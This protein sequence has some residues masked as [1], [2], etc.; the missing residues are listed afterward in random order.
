[1]HRSFAAVLLNAVGSGADGAYRGGSRA[2]K[3]VSLDWILSKDKLWEMTPDEFEKLAGTS[4]F[5]WQD[6]ER[7]RARFDPE[8]YNFS[9]KGTKVGETLA[10]FKGG[11]LSGIT[12]SVLNKGDDDLIDKSTYTTA[13]NAMRTM[14]KDYSGVKEEA[15]PHNEAVTRAAGTLWR[16]PKALCLLEGLFVEATKE[17]DGDWIITYKE[18]AEFVRAR[19]LPPQ[20]MLGAGV[21]VVKTGVTG[22]QLLTR[23][24]REGTKVFID[25]VP[26]VDQGQKGYCAVASFERVLR[27]YGADVDMHDLANLANTYGG[28]GPKGM[29]D[30]VK[31]ISTKLGMA[32]REP[33]LMVEQRHFLKLIKDY[34][35]V[36]KRSKLTE[37]DN[38]SD[39]WESME[40]DVL[41]DIRIKTQEFMRFKQEI[42]ANINKGVPLMWALHLGMYWED[43][44]NESYEANRY[45]VSKPA[46]ADDKNDAEAAKAY[47][48]RRAKAYEELRAKNKRPPSY[49]QGGH[50]RLIIGYDSKEGTILYTDSWG[51]GHEVKTMKLEDAFT[52]T[53]ALMVLEPR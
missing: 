35:V 43:K 28:T 7:T 39:F 40:S 47:A 32:T 49:M 25:T 9:I 51:P 20:M 38:R 4:R 16:S 34:N 12:I 37:V 26:M 29:K 41:R 45:A 1:M 19:L 6:K 15:R 44:M 36:A 14:L 52:G 30:A 24:K 46:D 33:F 31:K 13:M 21:P 27:Y 42:A 5:V 11:K 22:P 10:S 3:D 48:E 17:I 53:M 18:H 23:V 2:V 50:M 8:D